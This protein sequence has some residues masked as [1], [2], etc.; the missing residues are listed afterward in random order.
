MTAPT[1]P[2]G[3]TEE[4][5]AALIAERNEPTWMTQRRRD[6]WQAY[7]SLPMPDPR[8]DEEWRRTPL[9]GLKLDA[10]S[11]LGEAGRVQ[12]APLAPAEDL[13]ASLTLVDGTVAERK[14]LSDEL[15]TK[16]VIVTDLRTA[17][18]EHADLIEKHFMTSA[19]KAGDS[20]F[21]ALHGAFWD[22]GVF[23][24]VPKGV[25]VELPVGVVV[26]A[27]APGRA[28]LSHTLVVLER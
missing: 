2:R 24:Y 18:T 21:A 11:P 7:Q 13:A 25:A 17:L 12:V 10:A 26:Q 14:V 3:F 28:S 1:K 22:N 5:M 19:V 20:K 8:K 4:T 16:G 6:A 23:V 9:R 27:A 15:R